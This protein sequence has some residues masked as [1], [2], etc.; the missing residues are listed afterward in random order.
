[1]ND[2]DCIFC[3]IVAGTLPSSKIYEDDA[4]LAFLD[5]TPIN[6]G[7][8]LVVPKAHFVNIFDLPEATYAAMAKT[9]QKM[10]Q[11]L[12]SGMG[13]ENV[14]VYMNNGKHSGQVVFHAH[15]HIIPRH[16]G[17]GHGLWKGA[18]YQP[19]EAEQISKQLKNALH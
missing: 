12:Q 16:E 1:M 5:S 18:P 2:T 8:I 4:T 13:I 10:A 3:K 14:N 11:T 15:I 9:A 19:G 7:H 6:P 17:D